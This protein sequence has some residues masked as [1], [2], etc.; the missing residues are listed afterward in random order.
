MSRRRIIV[1]EYPLVARWKNDLLRSSFHSI[2]AK[3]KQQVLYAT[4]A[5]K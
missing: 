1:E 2:Y 4:S 3:A 5:H